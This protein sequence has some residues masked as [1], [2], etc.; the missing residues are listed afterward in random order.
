MAARTRPCTIAGIRVQSQVGSSGVVR[1]DL[2][3]SYAFH[4][5]RGQSQQLLL[6]PGLRNP[7]SPWS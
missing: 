4:L 6:T 3:T 1:L 5:V 2:G 7:V